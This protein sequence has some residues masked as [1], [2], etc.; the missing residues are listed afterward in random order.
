MTHAIG[1]FLAARLVHLVRV[2]VADL[3]IPPNMSH[4]APDDDS[5]ELLDRFITKEGIPWTLMYDEDVRK[6]KGRNH[7]MAECYGISEIPTAILVDQ[8]RHVVS[9][10]A[11]GSELSK[12]LE[13]LLGKTE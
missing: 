1:Y 3:L 4:A 11:R 6:G 7:P 13:K 2:T 9:L 12:L 8:D 5:R 10:R